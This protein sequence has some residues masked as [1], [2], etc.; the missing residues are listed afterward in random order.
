MR[1][2]AFGSAILIVLYALSPAV[3]GAEASRLDAKEL[4]SG[5]RPATVIDNRAFVA[6]PSARPAH[7]P[8]DGDLIVSEGAMQTVPTDLKVR[9]LRGKDARYFP[10][11]RL[12]FVTVD[13]DLVPTT[14]DVIHTGFA[15][16]GRSYW[17]IIVQPGRV[18]SE[19]ADGRWSRA[20]FPFALVNSLEGETHNGLAIF[21]YRRHEVSAL[22]Y[23]IVQQTLPGNV[24]TIFT[25]AG[26]VPARAESGAPIDAAMIA[27]RYRA[28]LADAVP[29]H[30]WIELEQQVGKEALAG[31]AD[32]LP[33]KYTVLSGLDYNGALYL[34]ECES[35]GGPLPWCDR[36]RFGVWSVTK[37][38]INEI[39]LLRLA[40]KYG[41]E[42]FKTKIVDYVPAA[43]S[44]PA[45]AN[46]TFDDCINMATGIGNGS[47]KRDP[48][49]ISDGFLDPTYNDWY[50]A[51]S[52]NDKISALLRSARVYPWGP[53]QV[54][55]YRDQDMY[56]L[57]VAM[58]A[59]IK[60]REGRSASLWSM[61][62]REVYEPIGI[63]YATT[64]RT[65]EASGEGVPPMGFG[66]YATLD[67]LVKV[68]RLYHARG[69][70]HGTQILYAPKIDQLRAGIG[71]RGLASGDHSPFGE[72]MYFNAF[73][74]F[75][76]D[77]NDGCKLYIPQMRGWGS[78]VVALYP[79]GLT[80]IQIARVPPNS[81]VSYDPTPMARVANRLVPFCR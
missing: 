16:K 5:T 43:R 6:G 1:L 2:S 67:E 15:T 17:D 70:W 11:V 10:A 73:W 41:P 76:Y 14:Q 20:A 68:S 54:A 63:L 38:F 7:A 36:A 80:G 66:V 31:F 55:R 59:F 30:P 45:W 40:Q 12:S 65:I 72:T 24:E 21:L 37:S 79:G 77:A 42:V 49:D 69:L 39:A 27:R 4:L 46:V 60:A 9:A 23:Q 25:A 71:Q 75:R 22:R 18:W 50:D 44:Y 32:G 33:A 64:S 52:R 74:H 61:V 28:A 48:N 47:T 34:Q 8:F 26:S 13:G 29:V 58:D 51:L 81:N 19:P 53:G 78:D 56:I 57:G 62:Q 35:A 3:E